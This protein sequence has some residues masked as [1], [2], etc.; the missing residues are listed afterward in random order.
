MLL[1]VFLLICYLYASWGLNPGGDEILCA[2]YT[3][4]DA[5]LASCMMGIGS[6]PGQKWPEYGADHPLPSGAG[7]H[8]VWSYT[9]ASLLCMLKHVMVFPVPLCIHITM[10]CI[11]LRR[12]VYSLMS[13]MVNNQNF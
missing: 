10:G 4:P 3:S 9:S 5:H 6:F 2:V 8:R 13:F 11:I 12:Y 7:F 1:T